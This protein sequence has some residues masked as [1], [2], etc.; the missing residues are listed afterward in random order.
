MLTQNPLRFMEGQLE[1]IKTKGLYRQFKAFSAPQAPFSIVEGKRILLLSS[2]NYLGLCDDE[3]LK[4]AAK[5]AIEHYGTGAGG[6]RLTTG[7]SILHLELEKQLAL[8]KK[9]PACLVFNTGY[10][11]NLGT[12]T[13]LAGPGWAVYC[14]KL[15]HASIIDGIRLSGA[16]LIVYKH[17]DTSDLLKKVE[18]NK[19][20]PGL[21]VTDGVFSMDGD[22]APLPEI[23]SIAKHY[24]LIS[25]VDDAHAAGILGENGSGTA[26]YFGLKD[27]VDVQMGTLSKAFASEGGYVAGPE[28]LIDFLKHRARSFVYS[29]ALAPQ[30]IAVSLK[31][32]EIIREDSLPRKRLL[33]N[34]A[35]FSSKLFQAGFS[36]QESKTP[37]IPVM[38]GESSKAALY[39]RML[40]EEGVFIPAIRPPTVKEGKSRLRIS[41]MA[42]HSVE[43]LE[44]AFEKI[45]KTMF[46]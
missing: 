33:E 2:N 44:F 46:L 21:I 13:A 27:K 34:A 37:I 26:E 32:L 29:T 15:N 3:R 5:E 22:I 6:S 36:V 42:T 11:A 28:V 17:C 45:K 7:T 39:S 10:M 41:L 12:I 4:I 30:T 18:K 8:F 43:D 14:D 23:T 40:F 19:N 24:G 31:A 1:E 16:E 20:K 35:W 38:V 9:T 25:M